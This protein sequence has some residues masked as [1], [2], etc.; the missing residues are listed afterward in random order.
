MRLFP[1]RLRWMAALL[2]I[3]LSIAAQG[4]E[5]G[6]WQ[7]WEGC[8]VEADQYFD[9]DSFQVRHGRQ[10]TIIRLYFVDTPETY[11]GYASLVAAQA[12]HFLVSPATV[13]RG[14]EK[15]KEF[16]AKFLAGGFRVITRLQLAPGA[17][18]SQR[19]YGIV[20]AKG[21]RLDRVLVEEGLARVSSE[22][23]EYPDAASGQR[24][25]L[26]LRR[27]EQRAA[28]ERRGVWRDANGSKARM[29]DEIEAR[30]L[31]RAG[32]VATLSRVNLNT[33]T[34][35]ELATLPG[36][37]AKTAEQ[38]IRARPI[39]NLEALDAVPGIGPKKI[40]ALR[41]LIRFE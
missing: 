39:K 14:G 41:D 13:L 15:A 11:D 23:G 34:A 5:S 12:A 20:E 27:A 18:R 8:R 33:A 38:L 7:V 10:V 16:T 36:I 37:G 3:L 32:A 24:M 19:F 21:R 17:S 9:G 26:E 25:M 30:F 4:K 40:E 28:K 2:Q 35:G 1:C 22:I 31:N 6:A 29:G